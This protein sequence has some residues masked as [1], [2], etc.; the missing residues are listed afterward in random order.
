MKLPAWPAGISSTADRTEI[1]ADGKDV[2]VFTAAIVDAEGRTV[3]TADNEM[4]FELSG[5]GK[6]IGVG[7]GDPTDHSADKPE[8]PFTIPR[9]PGV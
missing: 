4:S 5:P 3:P 8:A 9:P 1:G 2:S 7:N 6:V